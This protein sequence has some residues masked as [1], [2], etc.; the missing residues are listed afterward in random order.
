MGGVGSG[1]KPR[2]YPA[3][4]VQL[5]CGMYQD[6]KTVAEIRAV[7]PKGY[8]IQTILERYLPERRPAAKRN[9]AGTANHMWKGSA[10]GYQ[11]AHL[12]L[13]R[14]ADHRCVDCDNPA[15]HWSYQHDCPEEIRGRHRSPYCLHP[16]H[17]A[18]RCVPCHRAY[19]RIG[20]DAK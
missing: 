1:S 9:Q 19:D 7:A 5:I 13:G 18:P 6:G 11:A 17:Y 20:G 14:A 4:I 3:E 12:R 15:R 16:E 8:R 2:E 10:A